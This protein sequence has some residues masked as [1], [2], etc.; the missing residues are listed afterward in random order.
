[1][2]EGGGNVEHG[3]VCPAVV[4]L[5]GGEVLLKGPLYHFSLLSVQNKGWPVS[6]S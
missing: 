5:P 4:G 1:M 2:S 6:N 3:Q